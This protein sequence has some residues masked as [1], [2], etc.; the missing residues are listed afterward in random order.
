MHTPKT[1]YTQIHSNIF[2]FVQRHGIRPS[3]FPDIVLECGCLSQRLSE[4]PVYALYSV[5]IQCAYTVCIFSVHIHGIGFEARGAVSGNSQ[6]SLL[7]VER[8]PTLDP[9]SETIHTGPQYKNTDFLQN[10][11]SRSSAH[12]AQ[13]LV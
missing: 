8:I 2:V 12:S 6:A 3:R 11:I 9:P 4:T 1:T 10:S 5:H 13:S 7:A